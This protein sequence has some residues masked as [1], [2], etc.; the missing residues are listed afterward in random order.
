MEKIIIANDSTLENVRFN[1]GHILPNSAEIKEKL[2][3]FKPLESLLGKVPQ[4]FF[5]TA[6][7]SLSPDEALKTIQ[8]KDELELFFMILL[9]ENESED[10]SGNVS[11]LLDKLISAKENF[12]K[13][14]YL[15]LLFFLLLYAPSKERIISGIKDNIEYEDSVA[16]LLLSFY[17]GSRYR[18]DE[19]KTTESLCAAFF[20]ALKAEKAGNYA[21]AF[22]LMLSVFE[23]S[24]L[25]PFIFEILKFY[26]IQYKGIPA[27]K[28]AVFTQKVA[29]SSLPV[30]FTTVKFAEFIYY[31]KNNISEALEKTVAALAENT[32]SVFILNIIAP[33]LC[34]YKKWH[35]VGKF[36]KS[37]SKKAVGAEK[38][39]YLELLADIYENKLELPDFANEIYKNNAEE[40][41]VN[42]QISLSRTALFYEEGESWEQLAKLY[43]F[44]AEKENG[45]KARAFFFYKA[46]EIFYRRLE[47]TKKATE[48]FEK[49][50]KLNHSFENARVLAEIYLSN[51][52]NEG[53]AEIIR[54]ELDSSEDN[55]EKIRL[56]EKLTQT[57]RFKPNETDETY[58]LEI[59]KLSP[60]NI[61]ALKKLGKIYYNTK[62][63][64]KLVEINFKEIDASKNITEII[65]L[66]YRNGVVF[67][68]NIKDL[69]RAS[70]CFREV[71]DIDPEHLAT[72]FYLEK[73]YAKTSD[74]A[75]LASVYS[76]IIDLNGDARSWIRL[77]YLT[78]LALTFRNAGKNDRAE[79]IFEEIL[80]E[81]PENLFAKEN[82]RM[83]KGGVDFSIIETESI[84]YDES[85]FELFIDY[86]KQ[87][88][89]FM[90]TD[91]ILKR[92][93]PSFWKELYFL[94]KEG[95]SDNAELF[96]DDSEKFVLSLFE[97]N[98]SIDVL[99]QNQS[100]KL[101]QILLA[102]EYI[103]SRFFAGI[104]ILLDYYLKIE[105]KNKRKLWSLFF[106]GCGNQNLKDDLE[107]ALID[108]PD[109]QSYDITREILEHVYIR[110]RDYKTALF[111]RNLA[112]QKLEN[113]DEKCRF[114][115]ETIALLGENISPDNLFNL[116]KN[117]IKFTTHE[118]L[119]SFF[120]I[121]EKSLLEI[122]GEQ[123]L[124]PLY[125]QKWDT[126]KDELSAKKLISYLTKKRDF[127]SAGT[128]AEELFAKNSTFENLESYLDILIDSG[129]TEAAE[130]II[131]KELD[132]YDAETQTK[133]KKMLFDILVESGNLE[134]AYRFYGETNNE[135][136][137]IK[138]KI[139]QYIE[140]GEFKIAEKSIERFITD[141]FEQKILLSKI[142]KKKNDTATEKNILEQLLPHAVMRHETY[143]LRRF[144]ELNPNPRLKLLIEAAL[145]SV[146]GS[147]APESPKFPNIFAVEKDEIFKFA[148][149]S[150]RDY[151]LKEFLSLSS[152]VIRNKE[153]I[154]AKPLHSSDHRILIQLIEYI[155]LSCNN[156][157]LEGLWNEQA[158][159]PCEAVFSKIPCIV[160]GPESLK[161]DFEELKFSAVRDSFSVS[162]GISGNRNEISR[163]TLF[164]LK[165]IGKDK[166]KF[167]KDIQNIYQQR[168][169]ELFKLLEN[170]TESDISSFISKMDEASFFYAFS[171]VPELDEAA[172][173]PQEKM[174]KFISDFFISS[175]EE[176]EF[177][178]S[179]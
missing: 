76:Q 100:K 81:N 3:D 106:K 156:D 152:K 134:E 139:E 114:L 175:F 40:D 162:C 13:D 143:P 116:Y 140:S 72:L 75:G 154:S 169:L 160:F 151:L 48:C 112:F 91:E 126:E 166:I 70:E 79:K 94:F 120:E 96:I 1:F 135:T 61:N 123:F 110:N 178:I 31:Y 132:S 46:G 16:E 51:G 6:L 55:D 14:N 101:A 27:E 25:H 19:I 148:G 47:D 64:E 35:L 58:L 9:S 167:V 165:L 108:S 38:T 89:S 33:L 77:S 10:V 63:W 83:L 119:N 20:E 32:N 163:N 78:K 172:K 117:R 103:K 67:Y 12:S 153:N 177:E 130:N 26:I 86:I 121:H 179:K 157:E 45:S 4:N 8:G 57:E 82:L 170:A 50:I 24:G 164:S 21:E 142:A 17:D 174:E 65:N 176:P 115:D 87:N 124:V 122:G 52:N 113:T 44:V 59:L 2:R 30:S 37:A 41:P 74:T 171:L 84:D 128:I 97:K 39:K 69:T 28:I 144:Y 149:F 147:D 173:Q 133:L 111:I 80:K 18:T 107:E 127:S 23:K 131:K 11:A 42:C 22:T 5:P 54:G 60:K 129:K 43:L 7:T 150:E 141:D 161:T 73:I 168:V 105:P 146:D 85:N 95:R 104:S 90:M 125:K 155:R 93:Q 56:L 34:K 158:E 92:E 98:F 118:N 159:K 15:N 29:E 49:S 99:V 53:F 71:L 138:D 136:V 145:R 36:Y 68:E 62:N 88:D 102:K 109:R 137:E 66:Y